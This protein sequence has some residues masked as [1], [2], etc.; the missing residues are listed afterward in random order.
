MGSLS[1]CWRLVLAGWC[2]WLGS[3]FKLEREELLFCPALG[4]CAS[5]RACSQVLPAAEWNQGGPASVTLSLLQSCWRSPACMFHIG[6]KG[7]E[8]QA[9]T[10]KKALATWFFIV[11]SWYSKRTLVLFFRTRVLRFSFAY[12][13]A[14]IIPPFSNKSL[15]AAIFLYCLDFLL[16]TG[17]LDFICF[18]DIWEW[19]PFCVMAISASPCLHQ[20]PGRRDPEMNEILLQ[21]FVCTTIKYL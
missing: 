9:G 7:R 11:K 3:A 18:Y 4:L 2:C 20:L 6:I 5:G 8:L 15:L 14:R 1:C 17:H 13:G 21:P 12:S 19:V 10:G 16:L